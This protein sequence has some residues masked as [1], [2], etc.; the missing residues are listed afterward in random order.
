MNGSIDISAHNESITID[1]CI[2]NGIS[3]ADS[4]K[5]INIK[6]SLI[7]PNK[8]SKSNV[9]GSPQRTQF[10]N[11]IFTLHYVPTL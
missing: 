10:L 11:C 3:F 2:L 6:D 5:K 9:S 4:A 8:D 7:F 1:N